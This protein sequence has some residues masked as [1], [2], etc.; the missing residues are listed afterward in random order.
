MNRD[1]FVTS[2]L[3]VLTSQTCLH[4]PRP[5][6]TLLLQKTETQNTTTQ[7][8][9]ALSLAYKKQQH[10]TT[11]GKLFDLKTYDMSEELVGSM[12]IAEEVAEKV[13]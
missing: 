7:S 4:D 3:P 2:R 8:S 10:S 6:S 5:S 11:L 12:R 1:R 9:T 13:E